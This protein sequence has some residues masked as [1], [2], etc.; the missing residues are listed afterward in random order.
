[1]GNKSLVPCDDIE[2]KIQFL[3]IAKNDVF[4]GYKRTIR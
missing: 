4:K 2:I 3:E 1:M